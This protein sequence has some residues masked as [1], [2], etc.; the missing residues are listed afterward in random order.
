V[1]S[2]TP[3]V[4]GTTGADANGR[5]AAVVTIPANTASGAHKLTVSGTAA[6][7]GTHSAAADFTVGGVLVRTG[8]HSDSMTLL[9]LISL[10]LGMLLVAIGR[11][12]APAYAA[13]HFRR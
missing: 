9:A 11:Q 5:F 1:L 3:Q 4:L 6:S 7:G 8:G 10:A 12:R 2:S 13:K